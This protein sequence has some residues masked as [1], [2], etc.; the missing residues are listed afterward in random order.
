[1]RDGPADGP[2]KVCGVCARV[3]DHFIG[4]DGSGTF[5]HSRDFI[6]E[7]ADHPAVPVDPDEVQYIGRCD[8][9]DADHPRWVLPVA[10]FVVANDLIPDTTQTS[11]GGWAACDACKILLDRNAWN[12]LIRN[13]QA[14]IDP[15]YPEVKERMA[16]LYRRLRKNVTGA[17][18]LIEREGGSRE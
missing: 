6:G 13:A 18:K 17:P 15:P 3:L 14:R 2:A 16:G 8:F 9:C 11:D 10:D 5:I 1:M 12:V 4:R 7:E